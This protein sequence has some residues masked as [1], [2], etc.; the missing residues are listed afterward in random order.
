MGK[1]LSETF[2]LLSTEEQSKEKGE[3]QEQLIATPDSKSRLFP[4][5]PV[6]MMQW[7][8]LCAAFAQLSLRCREN[9][10]RQPIDCELGTA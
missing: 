10:Q 7:R 8:C 3:N 5:D 9:T 4:R 6:T 2:T 1:A